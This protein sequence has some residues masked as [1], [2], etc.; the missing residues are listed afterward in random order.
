MKTKLYHVADEYFQILEDNNL[1]INNEV[2][3]NKEEAR[4]Y[5]YILKAEKDIF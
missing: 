4:P 5:F 3:W 2:V 1:N